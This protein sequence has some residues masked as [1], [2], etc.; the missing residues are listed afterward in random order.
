MAQRGR[1]THTH[2]HE[3]IE[4]CVDPREEKEKKAALVPW[5]I[6]QG[7]VSFCIVDKL[8]NGRASIIIHGL[9]EPSSEFHSCNKAVLDK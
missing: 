3:E 2:T 1:H 8:L 6:V 9:L 4:G 7:A 5:V